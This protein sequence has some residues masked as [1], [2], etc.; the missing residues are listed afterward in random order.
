VKQV[1][2]LGF[3]CAT[4]LSV[5]FAAGPEQ[6][7][8]R[9]QSTAQYTI[10]EVSVPSGFTYAGANDVNAA[11]EAVGAAGG[12]PGTQPIIIVAGE[13]VLLDTLG[14]L[15]NHANAINDAGQIAGAS[16]S[17]PWWG[18]KAVR[19]ELDGSMTVVM[20]IT[21]DEHDNSYANGI[22]SSG[23]IVGQS[24]VPGGMWHAFLWD[25]NQGTLD[26][27]TLGGSYSGANDIND[28]GVVIGWSTGQVQIESAFIWRGDGM[29][30]LPSL[31]GSDLPGATARAINNHDIIVGESNGVQYGIQHA[32]MWDEKSD[33]HALG[34]LGGISS[35]AYDVNDAGTIVGE[36]Q[37]ESGHMRAFIYE[38]GEMRDLNKRLPMNS[39]WVLE[40]AVSISEDGRIT[41]YGRHNGVF[42]NFIMEPRKSVTVTAK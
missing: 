27:G 28:H 5:A 18:F 20:P 6:F 16:E 17:Q 15:Y 14:G 23:Q 10:R 41:G 40:T 9:A 34:S 31:A 11:G 19:W 35:R 13:S 26:L 37:I 39:G 22:N 38:N 2:I 30:A 25:E 29:T 21:G 33:I 42:R 4:T 36:A 24:D 7:L 3:T 1:V 32:V 8:S 12:Q